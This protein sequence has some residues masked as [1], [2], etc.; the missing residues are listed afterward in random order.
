MGL[1]I[2]VG[3]GLFGGLVLWLRG[4]NPGNRNY[5]MTI[6]FEDT[7]GMQV[8]TSVQYRGV[9][10]GRV[11]GINPT[12][13]QVEVRLEIT[14]ST[15][16]IPKADLRVAANQSGFIGET[17]IDITPMTD[18][19]EAEQ[20]ISPFGDDC[21]PE[22]IVCDGETLLGITGVSYASLLESADSLAAALADPELME[23]FK[24]TLAN[25]TD[26]TA[27]ATA[28]AEEL[29]TLTMTA[30]SEVEPLSDSVQAATTSAA[31]AAQEV[32]LTA[33]EVRTLLAANR[34]NITS[35]LTNVSQGS[36]RLSSILNQLATQLE[37][38]QLLEDLRI[39]SA[40]AAEA[41]GYFRD[42]AIDLSTLTGAINQPD[43][44]L[45]LQQSLESARDVF[46]GV[47]KVLSDIDEITGDPEV[48][49]NIR[50]L[51]YGLSDLLSSV[52][53][54]EYQTQL[55]IALAPL[56][57]RAASTPPQSRAIAL[58]RADYQALQAQLAE[59]ANRQPTP[60]NSG[61]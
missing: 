4:L 37:D 13:N 11:V 16:R 24:E 2:L 12:S 17:T 56:E 3:V 40:N 41:S 8:G 58:S 61:R 54:L 38:P 10:V 60:T 48:R 26:F 45:L 21:D 14:Q 31:A 51:I 53:I 6:I 20:A 1:L 15:L 50:R 23:G 52:E 44:V 30:Q 36:E 39:L 46:Q 28:L 25:T 9:P 49:E 7:L 27:Q 59:L 19:T 29:T 35:T 32:Q 42:A 43:N 47:Q 5:D 57:Q 22:V 34:V 18:L 33:T 55:A